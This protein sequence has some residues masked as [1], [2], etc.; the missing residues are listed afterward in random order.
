MLDLSPLPLL[1]IYKEEK[2]NAYEQQC[3][4]VQDEAEVSATDACFPDSAND[5]AIKIE[6]SITDPEEVELH[7]FLSIMFDI[8]QPDN[9]IDDALL[10]D[11]DDHNDDALQM[12]MIDLP[13]F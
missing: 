3:A 2:G 8:Y 6:E 7:E 13:T 9:E 11:F 4:T 5:F 10:I 12:K 1:N